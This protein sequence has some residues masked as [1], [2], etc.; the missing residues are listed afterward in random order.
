MLRLLVIPAFVSIMV[1]AAS[2]QPD[3][4]AFQMG[5]AGTG[6]GSRA[7]SDS[8]IAGGYL[9]IT[10]GT[11]TGSITFRYIIVT[12]SPTTTT[13]EILFQD[14]DQD[15]VVFQDSSPTLKSNPDGRT[16][17]ATV[18]Y[19]TDAFHG[20]SG[21]LAYTFS[22]TMSKEHCDATNAN[23]KGDFDFTLSGNGTLFLSGNAPDELKSALAPLSTGE[24]WIVASQGGLGAL[25]SRT[26]HNEQRAFPHAEAGTASSPSNAI[27]WLTPSWQFV[28]STYTASA[29]CPNLPNCWLNVPIPTGTI[30]PF[31]NTSIEFDETPVEL[32][33]GV[34]PANLTVSLTPSGQSTA[35]AS[36][37]SETALLIVTDGKPLLQL[38][39]SSV[40]FHAV[41]GGGQDSL[42]HS[43]SLS[44][45]DATLSYFATTATSSGGNW[46]SVNPDSGSAAVDSSATITIT[47][48]LA[49]LAPGS[50]FGRVDVIA[51]SALNNTQSIPVELD[52]A[53]S[54]GSA[55][56]FSTTGMIF[57]TQQNSNPSAQ[58]LSIFTLSA[59]PI[60]LSVGQKVDGSLNWLSVVASGTS[61]Q[62]G[63][64]ADVQ[65]SV[66]AAGLTPGIYN[67]TVIATNDSTNIQYPVS[68]LLVVTPASGTCTP[69]QLIPV[70]TDLG[71]DFDL[72][73]GR[74]AALQA[75]VLDDCGS[76]LTTGVV[77]VSFDNNDPRALLTATGSGAWSGTW[78]PHQVGGGRVSV[79]I[80]AESVGGLTGSAVVA[81]VLDAN[82]SAVIVNTGGIANGASFA[83]APLSPG[84]LI[85][86][87]GSN[88]SSATMTADVPF[89]TE[90]NNTQVLLNGT[91]LPLQL[92]SSHQINAVVPYGVPVNSL[93]ELLVEQGG[94][95]SLP[96]T[97]AV[98]AAS[99]AVFTIAQTGQGVGA[100][101]Q[102][103]G[104]ALEIFCTGLGAVNSPVGDGAAAP[105]SPPVGTA[106]TVS[107]TVGGQ[108][109]TV[110]FSGL[111]PGFAGLYQVNV[112]IPSGIASG[113]TV[114]VVI[115][116]SGVSSPPVT[117]TIQ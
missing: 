76:S 2:A 95:Y 53:Q 110:L 11:L 25:S 61:I 77:Q 78:L 48:S 112:S 79:S 55:P 68:V 90:L 86:I 29:V 14:A 65:A 99:P 81:G 35:A 54:A 4:I 36:A 13:I 60:S 80:S 67:G 51:P 49:G 17:T 94:A 58:S 42:N 92:V 16:G 117:F 20:A 85:S 82:S 38:S 89:P 39:E 45:T 40:E 50:Y 114:P 106:N 27:A 46:L 32:G 10:G 115:T 108:T 31:T 62:S 37:V 52:I 100:I 97:V 3:S 15:F 19:G 24:N 56:Q 66:D 101:L 83:S 72:P 12:D 44:S 74:P 21:S 75:L 84:Q 93:Q 87:F 111:A 57:V 70:L 73:S 91:P 64:G 107:T 109:A 5:G 96:E 6:Y 1:L 34:Y 104:A 41:T 28:P 113:S 26:Y 22:C 71:P 59:A 116:V 18:L 47:A 7:D 33:P 30:A 9:V 43:V 88:L 105:V 23:A 8:S 102:V 69:T 98:A 63:Q 103:N